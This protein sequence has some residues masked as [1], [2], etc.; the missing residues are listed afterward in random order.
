MK[1]VAISDMHSML[2]FKVP[3]ADMLLIA[4]DLC[5]AAHSAYLSVDIQKNWL[6]KEFR[7]WIEE[8]PVDEVVITSGNHDWIF[9][10]AKDEVP[11]F[12]KNCHYIE[13]ESI[14]ILGLKIY[15][16]PVQPPFNDWAFNRDEKSIQK[17]WDNI[18]EGLDILLVHCP[19]YGIMDE[20]NH[21]NYIPEKIGCKRLMKRIKEVRP[22]YVVFGHNHSAHG[23]VEH[24]GI[25]YV[26]ASLVNE[27]YKMV[28]EPI[29]LEIE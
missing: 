8:Q 27:E 25:T 14:E 24:D 4:G 19:P 3:K 15:G 17:Y 13:D 1:V 5:P 16:S 29:V 22:K 20:T 28:R 7:T 18:P 23:V 26:N 21:P 11:A 12:N 9:E 2:N 10:V 6:N